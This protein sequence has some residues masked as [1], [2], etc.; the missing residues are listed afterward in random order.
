MHLEQVLMSNEW[1]ASRYKL[2]KLNKCLNFQV[3]FVVEFIFIFTLNV[4][5]ESACKQLHS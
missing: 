1:L 2:V 4:E 5:S 3:E